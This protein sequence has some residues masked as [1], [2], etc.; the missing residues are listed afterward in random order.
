[1]RRLVFELIVLTAGLYSAVS[2]AQSLKQRPPAAAQQQNE[3]TP[4]LQK[5]SESAGA[6][7]MAIPMSVGVGTPN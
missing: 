1:M 7:P 5:V 6:Q 4:A 2:V 3:D